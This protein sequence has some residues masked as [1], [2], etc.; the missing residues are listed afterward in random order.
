MVRE[1]VAIVDYDPAWPALFAAE[2]AHLSACL[3]P[4]LIGRIEHFG[5][6]SVPGLAAK[7][8][9]D[10]LIEA[11]D[12]DRVRDVAPPIL[13][14]QGYDYFWRPTGAGPADGPFYAW[15]VKRDGRGV[16]THHIHIVAKGF[17]QWDGL[18]FR[19]WLI[20]HPENAAEYA[21]L[22]RSLAGEHAADRVGY[23]EAKGFFIRRIVE[24]ARESVLGSRPQSRTSADTP[25]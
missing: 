8:I 22:K 20:A 2:A 6:T 4:G 24:R 18:L 15:F 12:L 17:P 23:T 3:P 14:A 7:P 10:L 25:P 9:V 11:L 16:R 1:E 19:D 5:S 13:E 21:A